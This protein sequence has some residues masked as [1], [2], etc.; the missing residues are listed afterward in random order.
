MIENIDYRSTYFEHPALTKIHGEPTYDT[1]Q[2]LHNELKSNASSVPSTLGGGSHGHLGLVVSS[3]RYVLIT[4]IPYIRPPPPGM[5]ILPPNVTDQ[6]AMIYRENHAEYVRI[7][8]EV[9]AVE[10]ALIQQ[11]VAA[12]DHTYLQTLCS[13]E[14]QSITIPVYEVIE[15]LFRVYGK[16]ISRQVATKQEELRP[17]VYD[18]ASPI[19]TMFNGIKDLAEYT[20][21]GHVPYTQQQIINFGYD[22]LNNTGKFGSYLREWSRKQPNE[23]T[24][25]NFQT[26]F[27]LA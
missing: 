5:R 11:I 23:Q 22:M 6:V 19:D 18:P 7:F 1:L 12:V 21:R 27:R 8:H 26:I 15:F 4:N 10:K 2:R 24:W 16:I 20:A 14:S 17:Q 13:R 25:T 9:T 3:A